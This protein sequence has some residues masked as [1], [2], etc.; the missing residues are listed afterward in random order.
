VTLI[1][2]CLAAYVVTDFAMALLRL[3]LWPDQPL[4]CGT[5]GTCGT[6]HQPEIHSDKAPTDPHDY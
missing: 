5:C 1:L 6:N 2:A 3:W 4:D